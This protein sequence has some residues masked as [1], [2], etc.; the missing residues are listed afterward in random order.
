[1]ECKNKISNPYEWF[2]IKSQINKILDEI[3]P[4]IIHAHNVLSARLV[5][6]VGKYP[7]IYDNHEYWSKYLE[8]LYKIILILSI[9]LQVFAIQK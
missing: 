9:F 4:D 8:T 1:L 3:R 5:Q 2:K 7:F 6:E